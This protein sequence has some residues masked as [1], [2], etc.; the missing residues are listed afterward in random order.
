MEQIFTTMSDNEALAQHELFVLP[1]SER[2]DGRRLLYAPLA[3]ACLWVTD[4][5]LHSIATN[6]PAELVD[7]VPPSQREGYIR[8]PEDFVNLSLLPNNI[9]NF[10]CSYC[11]SAYGRSHLQL[12]LAQVTA[13]IDHLFTQTRPGRK[14]ITIY[15]GGEP[16]LSWD[17]LVRPTL[18][19]LMLWQ[20]RGADFYVT[21]ITNGSLLPDGFAYYCRTMHIDLVCSFEVLR[22]VQEAQR[23]HYDLVRNNI[24]TLIR[25]GVIPA[26][27]SII[28]PLN[29]ER[30]E[31]MVREVQESYTGVRYLSF[32]PVLG[33]EQPVDDGFYRLFAEGFRQ[34]M[35]VA[36]AGGIELTCSALRNVDVTVE[37]YCA[38]ELALVADGSLIICPC[39]SSP[40]EPMFNHFVYGHVG[41]DGTVTID[42]KRFDELLTMNMHSQSWCRQC[43]ARWNCGG[44]CTRE[45][46]RRGNTP[47]KAFCRFMQSFLRDE[48]LARMEESE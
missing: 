20:Q 33:G 35:A 6:P 23:G 2:S 9:C 21:L 44:G 16:L 31:E 40:H 29:V 5:E 34:A 14:H 18:E 28:T 11:Y 13:A 15:G 36:Q 38:G 37:R 24:Q 48:L 8:T 26:L 42:T 27:N 47:D 4:D 7:V 32:E 41:T 22:D 19:H 46:L 12:Q 17:N 30:Q 43:F 25:D 45:T 10:H 3:D 1:G 39:L